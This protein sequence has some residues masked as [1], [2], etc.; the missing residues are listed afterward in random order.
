MK[1]FMEINT[2]QTCFSLLLLRS[3]SVYINKL[4]FFAMVVLTWLG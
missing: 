1:D 4:K 2:L 3:L